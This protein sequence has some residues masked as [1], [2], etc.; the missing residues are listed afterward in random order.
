MAAETRYNY[1]LRYIL[2]V[3]DFFLLNSVI[4]GSFFLTKSLGH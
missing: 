2:M 1:L 4:Y 3:M